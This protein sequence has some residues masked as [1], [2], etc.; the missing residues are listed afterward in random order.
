MLEQRL[1]HQEAAAMKEL[2]DRKVA[3]IAKE[4]DLPDGEKAVFDASALTIT[5][6]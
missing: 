1:A 6:G 3:D 4:L 2:A 5:F